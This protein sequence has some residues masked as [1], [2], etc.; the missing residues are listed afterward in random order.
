MIELQ[1]ATGSVALSPAAR[2]ANDP[3]SMR[4]WFGDVTAMHCGSRNG[5]SLTGNRTLRWRALARGDLC[6]EIVHAAVHQKSAKR[7]CEAGTLLPASR[8]AS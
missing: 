6:S 3:V 7:I 5:F 2:V 8:R 4:A 1:G